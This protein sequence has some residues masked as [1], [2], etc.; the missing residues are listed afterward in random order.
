MARLKPGVSIEQAQAATDNS[1]QIAR[2][3][4]IRSVI[5]E[6]SDNRNFRSLRIQL[7]SAAT[8][9]SSLSRQ[10]SEP[11]Q[12]LMWLVGVLLL[13]TCLNVAN[14]LLTRATAR[15]K[16]IAVRL[17]LGARRVRLVRQLLTEGLLLS[18]LGGLAGLL[19]TRWGTNVLLGFLPQGRTTTVF[20]DQTRSANDGIQS[21]RYRSIRT[22]L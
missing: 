17:A 2:E 8:G 4:D 21:R 12:V 7:N 9:S 20:G 18:A 19:F 22:D 3:P 13:I 15:Q 5:G 6:T 14:L 1:F 11:L 16:E 10:F